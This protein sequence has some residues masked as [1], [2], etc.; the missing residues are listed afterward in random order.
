M[1]INIG[2]EFGTHL[3]SNEIAIELV[4][5]LNKIPEDDFIL[6]F[7]EVIF[8]T[9]NFAQAYYLA[10]SESSKK[11]SEINISESIEVTMGS[12]DEAVNP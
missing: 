7:K 3:E 9:M 8:V 12:A 5:I 6:D 2:A 1:L 10:K 4:D 11:I